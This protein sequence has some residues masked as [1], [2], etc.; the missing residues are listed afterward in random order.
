MRCAVD[1][2]GSARQAFDS[3]S[4][5]NQ[6]IGSWNTAAVTTMSR[7]R[8]LVPSHACG[9]QRTSFLQHRS[10]QQVVADVGWPTSDK[11]E[12]RRRCGRV[13]EQMWVWL[14]STVNEYCI[15]MVMCCN[16]AEL[17]SIAPTWC[18]VV[19][20]KCDVWRCG[21]AWRGT[22]GGLG[23]VRFAV[24]GVGSALQAFYSASAFNQNIGSWNTASITT[25]S[26]VRALVPSHACHAARNRRP[27]RSSGPGSKWSR[28]RCGDGP[29]RM[30]ASPGA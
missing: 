17:H 25:M 24:D 6:N 26:S 4:A 22:A 12:S 28:R 16:E 8:I 29:P 11:G 3:A 27:S 19:C 23:V 10:R 14:G 7:V 20:C 2:V 15:Y 13:L 18:I 9:V 1:G 21:V 5:F 30:W